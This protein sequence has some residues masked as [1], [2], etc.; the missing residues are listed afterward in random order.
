MVRD[1]ICTPLNDFART[2]FSRAMRAQA[3]QSSEK[4]RWAGWND[5]DVVQSVDRS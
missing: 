3:G 4:L 2:D 5:T 1:G